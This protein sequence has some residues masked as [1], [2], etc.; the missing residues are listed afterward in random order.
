MIST[1]FKIRLRKELAKFPHIV[2]ITIN[3]ACDLQQDDLSRLGGSIG[4]YITIVGIDSNG[5]CCSRKQTSVGYSHKNTIRWPENEQHLICMDGT[6]GHIVLNVFTHSLFTSERF[7][8]QVVLD[9]KDRQQL[10]DGLSPYF[11]VSEVAKRFLYG[12][13]FIVRPSIL[14]TANFPSYD[15]IGCEYETIVSKDMLTDNSSLKLTL[16]L[17]SIF[18]SLCGTFY[19]KCNSLFGIVE[20]KK[21]WVIVHKNLLLVFNNRFENRDEMINSVS[22]FDI[23]HLDDYHEKESVA[24]DPKRVDGISKDGMSRDGICFGVKRTDNMGL[25][26]QKEFIWLWTED[27]CS[28]KGLWKRILT[29]HCCC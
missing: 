24:V 11:D 15:K 5:K 4:V 29:R 23:S 2:T 12:D 10:V 26:Y 7:L 16:S 13:N 6:N 20:I 8:G 1:H 19:E 28:L 3:K 25:V 22:L 9:M 27:T 17:P 21:V 14:R 18:S